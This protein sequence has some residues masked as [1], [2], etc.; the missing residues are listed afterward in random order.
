[1]LEDLKTY[2]FRSQI[3]GIEIFDLMS[4]FRLKPEIDGKLWS[5]L[6]SDVFPQVINFRFIPVIIDK[7]GSYLKIVDMLLIFDIKMLVDNRNKSNHNV[8]KDW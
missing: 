1:M 7:I 8:I 3:Q 6:K 4:H 2:V 5:K